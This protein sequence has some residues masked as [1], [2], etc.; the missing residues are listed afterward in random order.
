VTPYRRLYFFNQPRHRWLLLPLHLL[1]ECTAG[2]HT[3]FFKDQDGNGRAIIC[4]V[5]VGYVVVVYLV[6]LHQVGSLSV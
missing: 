5:F 6:E 2:A 4:L 3:R 1:V